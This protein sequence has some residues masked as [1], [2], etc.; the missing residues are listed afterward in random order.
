MAVKKPFI[1]H[2]LKKKRAPVL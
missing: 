2:F 1:G